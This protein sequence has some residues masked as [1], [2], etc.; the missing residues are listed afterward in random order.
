METVKIGIGEVVAAIPTVL[1]HEPREAVVALSLNE[2]GLPSCAF[3]IPRE[4]LLDS[5]S[6]AIT[7]AAVAEELSEDRGHLVLLV[8]Y[9]DSDIRMHCEALETLRLEVD[10]AVSRV[11]ALAVKDGRLFRPG[12]LDSECC[13]RDLPTVPAAYV[14]I[15]LAA[16]E[17][18]HASNERAE[19]ALARMELRLE[20][21]RWA[22]VAWEEALVDGVVEDAATARRLAATLDDLC[23]RDWVVLTLLGADP[24]A[25][26]DALEGVET[27]AVASAL[28]A[29]LAGKAKPDVLF[30]ER[31]RLV[32]ERVA[33]AARGRKRRAATTTL[34]AVLDWWEGN[35]VAAAERCVLALN[36]DPGY[37]LA[38]LV[39]L[40]AGRGIAPGW[41]AHRGQSA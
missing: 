16:R 23:V 33:R 6:A 28:D 19:R 11:E 22:A 20:T 36:H 39:S 21:R 15:V 10:L 25:A 30:T 26:E 12:C 4:V 13:P 9:A 24:E 18:T 35:L 7:A 27:G 41:L 14:N 31:A 29:A 8:S 2:R 1:G 37:R 5:D 3:E 34:V 32:V 38:E 40:A 17:R